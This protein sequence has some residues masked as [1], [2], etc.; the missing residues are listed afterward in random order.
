MAK[1]NQ[2]KYLGYGFY[3]TKTGKIKPKP[4]LKS[5]QKFKRKLKQLTKRS[6]S[7]LLKER[8][9]RL[10]QVIRGWINYFKI[11]DMKYHMRII[12]EH[13]RRRI[14]CLVWKQW[15]RS[16]KRIKML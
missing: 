13:L 8:I 16:T 2:I 11:A 12:G 3:Y 14:R 15:K 9:I 7:T 1:P 4:H 10:N 5:I 6:W